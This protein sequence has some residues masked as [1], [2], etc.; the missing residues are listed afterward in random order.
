MPPRPRA[1]ELTRD[2]RV[3]RGFIGLARGDGR[4]GSIGTHDDQCWPRTHGKS[5]PRAHP[6]IDQHRVPNAHAFHRS[7]NSGRLLF[8][9][10]LARV[11]A[12][13]H[14]GLPLEARFEPMQ[15]G[16]NVH[17]VHAARGEEI[18]NDHVAAQVA[19]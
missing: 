2:E 4:N 19:Q 6:F 1:I 17:A 5:M 14:D 16:C 7:L 15:D 8:V 10:E 18:Q 12:K 13:N 3:Q 11:N 9:I